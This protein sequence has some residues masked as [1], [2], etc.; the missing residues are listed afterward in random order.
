V[1][2]TAPDEALLLNGGLYVNFYT[3]AL[4]DSQENPVVADISPVLTYN[5]GMPG[6]DLSGGLLGAPLY[7]DGP[8]DTIPVKYDCGAYAAVNSQ[9]LLL[10]HHHNRS[11]NRVDALPLNICVL[12]LLIVRRTL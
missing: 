6:L 7:D 12:Y 2:L 11:G 9:G 3:I 1:T 4:V 10:F 5:A 8:G